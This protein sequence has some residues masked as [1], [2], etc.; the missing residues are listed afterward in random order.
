M[1]IRYSSAEEEILSYWLNKN[2]FAGEIELKEAEGKISASLCSGDDILLSNTKQ[3]I[4]LFL[5]KLIFTSLPNS[6]V[7]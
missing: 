4:L 6:L 7:K 3:P 2:N 1:E 5:S